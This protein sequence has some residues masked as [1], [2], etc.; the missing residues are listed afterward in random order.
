MPELYYAKKLRVPSSEIAVIKPIQG[1]FKPTCLDITLKWEK[2][3]RGWSSKFA[4]NILFWIFC[5]LF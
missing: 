4:R 3:Q 5:S 2:K 1:F